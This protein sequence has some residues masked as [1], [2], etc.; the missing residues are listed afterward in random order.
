MSKPDQRT[1]PLIAAILIFFSVFIVLATLLSQGASVGQAVFPAFLT[2]GI[3][4]ILS[5]VKDKSVR[6]P[7]LEAGRSDPRPEP[8]PVVPTCRH[9]RTVAVTVD[10]V[11]PGEVVG[12]ICKDCDADLPADTKRPG[13]CPEC[14]WELN[15]SAWP[16]KPPTRIKACPDHL[17]AVNAIEVVRA[18]AKRHAAETERLRTEL[19]TKRP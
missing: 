16:P 7:R 11:T 5:A 8:Q 3:I 1:N 12:Y 10:D 15:R 17:V 13:L 14:V 6:K 19:E 9:E 4:V 2:A 18:L